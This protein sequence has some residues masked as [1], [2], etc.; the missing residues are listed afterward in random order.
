[1]LGTAL[2]LLPYLR[3]IGML[4]LALACPLAYE[5]IRR[6]LKKR[7]MYVIMSNTATTTKTQPLD[8][9]IVKFWMQARALGSQLIVGVHTGNNSNRNSVGADMIAN[10]CS[11]ACVDEVIAEAPAKADLM[12]LEKQGIDYVVFAA[13]QKGVLV[14]DEVIAAGVCLVI[15]DDHIARPL[16]PKDGP[17]QE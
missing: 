2:F 5:S 4:F 14:T 11:T 9:K 16:R 10:A 17:K 7:V 1:M 6:T 15:G 13:G 12:F 3:Y 8:H